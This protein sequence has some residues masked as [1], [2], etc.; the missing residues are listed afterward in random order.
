MDKWLTSKEAVEIT[1]AGQSSISQ[2]GAYGKIRRKLIERKKSKPVYLYYVP[3][4]LNPKPNG[5]YLGDDHRGSLADRLTHKHWT[6][7]AL[8]L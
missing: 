1:G 3:D 6:P 7:E 2:W 5:T 8:E 4:L